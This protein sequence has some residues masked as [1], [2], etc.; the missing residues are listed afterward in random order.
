MSRR[1]L[2]EE[3]VCEVICL[4]KGPFP[5]YTQCHHQDHQKH[6][7]DHH[8]YNRDHLGVVLVVV[9]VILVVSLVVLVVVLAVL[10]GYMDF[11]IVNTTPERC[12]APRD[13][14]WSPVL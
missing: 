3:G 13:R 1:P 5:S 14:R 7:Q 2:I 9:V 10:V 11:G 4:T 12:L 6:H 8:H